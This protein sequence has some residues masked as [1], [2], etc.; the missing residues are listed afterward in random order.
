MQE[1]SIDILAKPRPATPPLIPLITNQAICPCLMPCINLPPLP[2][3]PHPSSN[4]YLISLHSSVL[5]T[6]PKM[7]VVSFPFQIQLHK[8]MT[9]TKKTQL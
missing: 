2:S 4:V 3:M 6:S 8:R 5:A 7:S 1:T 9:V